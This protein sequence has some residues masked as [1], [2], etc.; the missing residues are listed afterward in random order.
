[1]TDLN[2]LTNLVVQLRS[3]SENQAKQIE[4][5]KTDID[6]YKRK[7]EDC[8]LCELKK[9]LNLTNNHKCFSYFSHSK[10]SKLD[11]KLDTFFSGL[12]ND[13]QKINLKVDSVQMSSNP[14]AGILNKCSIQI[15]KET[16]NQTFNIDEVL[17]W[18][19]KALISDKSYELWY[20]I[21]KERIHSTYSLKKY[22]RYL[23]KKCKLFQIGKNALFYDVKKMIQLHLYKFIDDNLNFNED[24]MLK[25]SA[26]ATNIGVVNKI[27]NI[28]FTIINDSKSC[29][30]ASGN[31]TL[32]IVAGPDD[33]YNL[34]DPFEHLM[35][36]IKDFKNISHKDRNFGI[37][38][39]FGGDWAVTASLLGIK[40]ANC[41]FPCLWCIKA[42]NQFGTLEFCARRTRELQRTYLS[43]KNENKRYSCVHESLLSEIENSQCIIDTLHLLLRVTDFLMYEFMTK[44][45]SGDRY[46]D[47]DFNNLS[48]YFEGTKINEKNEF[49][50]ILTFL[51]FIR[52]ECRID[53]K[54]SKE[55]IIGGLRGPDKK[56]IFEKVH[57][58]GLISLFKPELKNEVK[59]IKEM[60]I[61]W[62]DFY[63]IYK[64]I[65]S[66]EEIDHFSIKEQTTEWFNTL[67]RA[68]VPERYTPY[69]HA[70][71]EHVW[72]FIRDH[73]NIHL[74]N[75]EGKK[76]K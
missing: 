46:S 35:S 53:F 56:K 55:K 23:N 16:I 38:Y 15:S 52:N 9:S 5:L 4:K 72:E 7:S 71:V 73:K 8:S 64:E 40:A 13:L 26:D 66:L 1:M 33:Y 34:K 50:R 69:V 12:N 67:R 3:E 24:F 10:K 36:I 70:F 19:D 60:D 29:M 48:E 11:N 58:V 47:D 6:N 37:N 25:I 54:L 68:V 27:T 43:N 57:D 62:R 75:E 61:L 59:N 17:Y 30:S 42:K 74:F 63:K 20:R 18:K 51:N 39:F 41:K 44:L 2:F 65:T 45:K 76:N 31:F 14:Q 49:N 28:T 22:R 21:N 32:G